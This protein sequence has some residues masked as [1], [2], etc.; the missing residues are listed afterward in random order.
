MDSA[1]LGLAALGGD[2]CTVLVFR[3]SFWNIGVRARVR[4]TDHI[5]CPIQSYPS[6]YTSS[7]DV[8]RTCVLAVTFLSEVHSYQLI[9]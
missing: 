7:L 9:L 1:V 6:L 4:V 5:E 8:K 3:G 2:C